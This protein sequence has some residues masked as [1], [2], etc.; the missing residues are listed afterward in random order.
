VTDQDANDFS[1]AVADLRGGRA[2]DAI[3][4]LESLADR[5]VVGSGIADD[6]GIAYAMRVRSGQ[7]QPGDLGRAAH[8]FEEA[9]RRDPGDRL[10]R[11]ALDDVRREVARRDLASGGKPTEV[12]SPPMWRAIVVAAPG[13]VWA[14]LALFGSI[15]LAVAL[16]VRPFVSRGKRLAASTVVVVGLVLAVAGSGLGFGARWVRAH[17]REA[18]IVAPDTITHPPTAAGESGDGAEPMRLVEGTRVDVVEE[19]MTEALVRTD[20]GEGWV[21]RSALRALPPYRP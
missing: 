1:A 12:G 10:A 20:R 2:E 9:L 5:G 6:R 7:G 16:G 11:A 13:D 18:V 17:V 21:P 3:A 19:R 15:A 4:L 8:A 14:A